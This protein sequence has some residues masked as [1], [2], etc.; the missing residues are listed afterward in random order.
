MSAFRA[1]SRVPGGRS[2][3]PQPLVGVGA[4][5]RSGG[6][7]PGSEGRAAGGAPPPTWAGRKA[8]A[9]VGTFPRCCVRAGRLSGVTLGR[10]D[11][12]GAGEPGT[13]DLSGGGQP[14]VP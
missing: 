11:G 8:E 9:S 14:E 7:D 2:P 13:E 5:E 12:G 1:V 10:A 3:P 4:G 6:R